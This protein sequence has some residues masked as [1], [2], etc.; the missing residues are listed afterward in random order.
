MRVALAASGS[1]PSSTLRSVSKKDSR[2]SQMLETHAKPA[3]Y[4]V[5][6]SAPIKH[7]ATRPDGDRTGLIE[8]DR[9]DYL[10]P[11]DIQQPHPRGAA[12]VGK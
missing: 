11:R 2:P 9:I 5:T 6:L 8:D 4:A 3:R 12:R 7:L 1:D 10:F